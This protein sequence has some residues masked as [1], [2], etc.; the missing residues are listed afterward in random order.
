MTKTADDAWLKTI[1]DVKEW[2]QAVE[3]QKS[4]GAK[5]RVSFEIINHAMSFD[6]KWPVVTC[7]PNT[8]WI[9]MAAEPM[10]V[11]EGSGNLNHFPEIYRIQ[12]PYSNNNVTLY[13]AYGP[14]YK[15]QKQNVIDRLNYDINTRQA[16]M[17]I[18]R[19]NPP[20]FIDGKLTKDIPCT[21][22]MQWLV[23]D[24]VIYTIVN[25]RSSDVGLGLPYDMLTFVC[26]TMD[27]AS[28]LHEPVELGVCHINAG[29]CHVYEDQWDKLNLSEMA[30][31]QCTYPAWSM[32][33][34]TAIRIGLKKIAAID[35]S[36]FNKHDIQG[37]AF[38]WMMEI[39]GG[40]T[41]LRS[42]ND[43]NSP[44]IK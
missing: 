19:R 40:K 2:G 30:L 16:V 38:R 22:S 32:W 23:R 37:E 8:S 33:K 26:M 13:G 6:M 14:R 27:I 24:K 25:M 1:R 34:W 18:W 31:K 21:V 35:V 44:S 39:S 41:N 29:S 17:S 42:N 12:A 4:V 11:I 9:Y 3:P 28:H 10:W 5:D 36:Q 43:K 7:K 20:L 15:L